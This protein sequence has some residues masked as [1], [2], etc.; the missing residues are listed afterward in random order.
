MAHDQDRAFRIVRRE[1]I[2][3][4]TR[5]LGKPA[6]LYSLW[7]VSRAAPTSVGWRRVLL[8]AALAS[9]VLETSQWML[10]VGSS[11]LT[12]I[13]M[14]STGG[15]VGY[16]LVRAV[17][18]LSQRAT[19]ETFAHACLAGTVLLGIACTAF[20]L[21]PFRY[22]P[23]QDVYVNGQTPAVHETVAEVH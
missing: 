17:R 23:M 9:T 13:I 3:R 15:I 21:S 6:D 20:A 5:S 16:V 8:V 18:A 19:M 22:A 12:D 10:A 2:E 4:T 14:N 1:R 7:G 11:D